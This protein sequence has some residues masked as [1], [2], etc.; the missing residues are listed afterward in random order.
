MHQNPMIS[1]R[2]SSSP[3]PCIVPFERR[4]S[5]KLDAIPSFIPSRRRHSSSSESGSSSDGS[6]RYRTLQYG[7]HDNL[8][9]TECESN[10]FFHYF[11]I[12]PH[13]P[14][15]TYLSS[16]CMHITITLYYCFMY[17]HMVLQPIIVTNLQV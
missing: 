6:L 12:T 1:P 7:F 15:L 4:G 9:H 11:V 10:S 13:Q 16:V 17:C 14:A 8:P 5:F 2:L 3:P